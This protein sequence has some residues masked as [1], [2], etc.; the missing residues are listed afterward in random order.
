MALTLVDRSSGGLTMMAIKR[1]RAIARN[2]DDR[3]CLIDD[4]QAAGARARAVEVLDGHRGS[5]PT[6]PSADRR[7]GASDQRVGR[8]LLVQRVERERT[9][10]RLDHVQRVE[11][12]V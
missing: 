12:I 5:Q 3:A 4:G 6:S 10:A 11:R 1:P 7:A 9:Y 8:R 2:L